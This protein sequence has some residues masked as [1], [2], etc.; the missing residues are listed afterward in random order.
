VLSV[1]FKDAPVSQ[2]SPAVIDV[3]VSLTKVG[4]FGIDVYG[5]NLE[6][7]RNINTAVDPEDVLGLAGL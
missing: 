6:R 2:Y 5:R 3:F 1:F 4:S 7:L